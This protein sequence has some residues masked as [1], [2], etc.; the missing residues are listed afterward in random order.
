[1]VKIPESISLLICS[2]SRYLELVRDIPGG[3]R[4]QEC[5]TLDKYRKLVWSSLG[6]GWPERNHLFRFYINHF[7]EELASLPSPDLTGTGICPFSS[8]GITELEFVI[9]RVIEV[10]QDLSLVQQL[11]SWLSSS[12]R[13]ARVIAI[14]FRVLDCPE[15]V[16]TYLLSLGHLSDSQIKEEYWKLALYRQGYNLAQALIRY[17]PSLPLIILFQPGGSINKADPRAPVYRCITFS[18]LI[19]NTWRPS[20]HLG[21]FLTWLEVSP[22]FGSDLLIK[23]L[24]FLLN[25]Y[26]V[27]PEGFDEAQL[28][29]YC[30]V[31]Q[32]VVI[33]LKA[34]E[35]A[36]QA[37]AVQD[38]FDQEQ[39]GRF[40]S[41]SICLMSRWKTKTCPIL[42]E[43]LD[44]GI[45]S[46][47]EG[48]NKDIL[49]YFLDQRSR[50]CC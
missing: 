2:R 24:A 12:S 29:R 36:D 18:T 41:L 13:A 43:L 6:P 10:T 45:V 50:L 30:R 26:K 7:Q 46:L 33:G 8:E 39:L 34:V 22:V 25:H 47:Q 48:S 17:R 11:I 40:Q 15:S 19:A 21:L 42:V 4:P 14:I 3:L 38:L 1:M 49:A 23:M 32:G 20:F 27:Y 16:F 35:L 28:E 5:R 9:C 44:L 31:I 37:S